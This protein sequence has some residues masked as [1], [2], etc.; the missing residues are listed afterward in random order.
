M[1]EERKYFSGKAVRDVHLTAADEG[2]FDVGALAAL[3]TGRPT[4]F[5]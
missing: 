5:D 1:L 4:V 3:G 2:S